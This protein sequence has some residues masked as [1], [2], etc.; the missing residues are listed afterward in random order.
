MGD[1]TLQD[2]EIEMGIR[3]ANK[4]IWNTAV[5]Q[6]QEQTFMVDL[7]LFLLNPRGTGETVE[8]LY[9]TS[10]FDRSQKGQNMGTH[11]S[12]L[13]IGASAAGSPLLPQETAQ[14]RK[15]CFRSIERHGDFF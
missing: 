12:L 14:M 7:S 4:R 9:R 2:S 13:L 6:K 10:S 11:L 15:G 5:S 8:G 1:D 3:R